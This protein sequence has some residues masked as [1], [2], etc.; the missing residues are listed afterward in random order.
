[1]SQAF[2]DNQKR[3]WLIDINVFTYRQLKQLLDVDISDPEA[4]F[5]L[6]SDPAS[7][8]D[9][10]YIVC[11][12]QAE[13]QSITDEDFGRAMGG[14]CLADATSAF[15]QATINFCQSQRQREVLMK[16]VETGKILEEKVLTLAESKLED[17]T[18]A[19][20]ENLISKEQPMNSQEL[21]EPIPQPLASVN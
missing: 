18:D 6:A 14:D 2:T 16:V 13:K 4:F 17:L 9:A 3:K 10:I 12:D 1:M 7:L 5:T 19:E 15:V 11:R 20:M 21:S 8:C